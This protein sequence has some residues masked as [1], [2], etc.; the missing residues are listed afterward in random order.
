MKG[1]AA[2]STLVA[3]LASC[4]RQAPADYFPMKPGSKRIMRVYTR[5]IAG[6]DTNETTEVKIVEV[7]IGERELPAMGK[8]WVVESPRD[9]GRT[10]YSYF[11]KAD[12]GVMQVV[13]AA[14]GKPPME[15]LYLSLP[16]AKG[17]KWYG[18]KAQRE[19]M[20]VVSEETVVV[21]AGTFTDCYQVL[22]TSTWAD[23]TMRQWFAPN[24]G[25]VK[26]ENH[27]AWTGKDGVR[28]ELLKRAELVRLQVPTENHRPMP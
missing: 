5:T 6:V 17:L 20:E 10:A 22:T 12:D 19:M 21:E 1:L 13:P 26:W 8:C 23:W 16:L 27:F 15:M 11:R 7:V 4:C 3:L 9:S 18:T 2:L 14:E 28:H 25:P 24:A